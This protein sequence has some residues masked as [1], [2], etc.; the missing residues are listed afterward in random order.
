MGVSTDAILAYG[1]NFGEDPEELPWY[2]D[3]ENDFD[4]WLY[5]IDGVSSDALWA[6][7]NLWLETA[8]PEIVRSSERVA[9]YERLHPEWRDALDANYNAQKEAQEACPIELVRHCSGDDPMYIVAVKDSV[10]TANR[11]SA[12][13]V[14]VEDLLIPNRIFEAFNFCEEYGIPFEDPQWLLCSMWW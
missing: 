8:D 13:V 3:G 9:L 5:T 7:Y 11:V 10:F 4:D 14:G 1:V 6:E 12:L 2:Q